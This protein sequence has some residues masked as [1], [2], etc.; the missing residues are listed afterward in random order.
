MDWTLDLI[1]SRDLVQFLDIRAPVLS[2]PEA[3][4]LRK[5]EILQPELP[6]PVA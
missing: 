1:F 2:R 4:T 6:E 5:S 3:Q